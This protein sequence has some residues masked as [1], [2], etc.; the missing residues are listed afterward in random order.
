M[1]GSAH[2]AFFANK[3]PVRTVRW[4]RLPTPATTARLRE[5][6]FSELLARSL[7]LRG[8]ETPAQAKD[9][10]EPSVHL[11]SEPLELS[12]LE[13]QVDRLERAIAADEAVC[14]VGDYDVDGVSASALL[15]AVFD[16]LGLDS[17]VILPD[18]RRH[19]YG[20]HADFVEQAR[21]AGCR[22]VLTVD[23][24]S[25]SRSTVQ[26]ALAAGLDVLVLDHHRPLEDLPAAA[27][28]VNPCFE[29]EGSEFRWLSAAG[30]A[31][32]LAMALADR[33]SRPFDPERLLRI[34]CLGTIADMVPLRAQNRIIS[35]VGLS[36]LGD[37]ASPGLQALFAA[38]GIRPPFGAQDVGFR[39]GPRLN[40]AGR[41]DRADHALE[42]LLTRDNGRAREIAQRLETLN[43]DRRS[44]EARVVEAARAMLSARRPTPRILVAW[45]PSWHPGVVG[46]AAGRLAREFHRPTILLV[47]SGDLT[48]GSGRSVAGIDLHGFIDAESERLVRFGGHAQAIGLTA[49][50]SQLEDLR[51]RWEE[52]SQEWPAERL[53]E[54]IEY[55]HDVTAEALSPDLLRELNRLRPFGQQSPE[56][57]L[58]LETVRAEGRIRRFGNGHVELRARGD[59]GAVVRIIGWRWADR[60]RLLTQPFEALGHL[61]EDRYRGGIRFRLRDARP[62]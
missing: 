7:A 32:E 36:A 35:A 34:A 51:S 44:E 54:E 3:S 41:L 46:I 22:I 13:A 27:L 26:K 8:V 28:H 49:R 50:T 55:E 47:N 21:Q 30:L 12:G 39:I 16:A 59:S 25:N 58:R 37:T 4:T 9:Y 45:E 57:M 18:R 15:K 19:G 33:C 11:L 38:A 24:G 61:E 42:L 2:S 6:G 1:R 62:A 20:F 60:S 40:A 31:F 17:R 23:C 48:T 56:P 43:R 14:I 5:A 29:D 53:E 10:L 52:A